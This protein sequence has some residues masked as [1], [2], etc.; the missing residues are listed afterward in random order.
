M[1]E[2]RRQGRE[3]R[4]KTD[5]HVGALG[6]DGDD[7]STLQHPRLGARPLQGHRCRVRRER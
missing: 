2:E 5:D 3:R 1:G 7:R 6:N 4:S